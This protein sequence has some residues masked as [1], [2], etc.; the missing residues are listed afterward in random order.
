M[1]N[2]NYKDVNLF[3]LANTLQRYSFYSELGISFWL[4]NVSSC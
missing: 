3:F 4:K 2:V 1:N